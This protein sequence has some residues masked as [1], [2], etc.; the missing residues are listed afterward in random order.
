[1]GDADEKDFFMITAI[2]LG[3]LATVTFYAV[4]LYLSNRRLRA[5]LRAERDAV[6]ILARYA[7]VQV[8]RASMPLEGCTCEMCKATRRIAN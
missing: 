4:A 2:L 3:A 8:V 6:D 7:G 1:M 5:K